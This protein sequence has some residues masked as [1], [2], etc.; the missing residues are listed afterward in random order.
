[1][2]RKVPPKINLQSLRRKHSILRV[3]CFEMAAHF[4]RGDL[5]HYDLQRLKP[6]AHM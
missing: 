1:M 2:L 4:C 6:G 3:R 5:H